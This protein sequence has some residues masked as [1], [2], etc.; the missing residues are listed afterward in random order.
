MTR[1]DYIVFQ[2][3]S[4]EFVNIGTQLC[5]EHMYMHGLLSLCMVHINE[6]M[7]ASK[8]SPLK[9]NTLK[10]VAIKRLFFL[11]EIIIQLCQ[12]RRVIKAQKMKE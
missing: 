8:M 1:Y 5:V 10:F 3:L 2:L 11:F 4:R 6:L 12:V 9:I 7:I